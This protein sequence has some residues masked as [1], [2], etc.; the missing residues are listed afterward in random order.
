MENLF[1][2]PS[3]PAMIIVAAPSAKAGAEHKAKLDRQV[4]SHVRV[5]HP[6]AKAVE[7]ARAS[8]ALIAFVHERAELAPMALESA[9]WALDTDDQQAF[10]AF[11][12]E[13]GRKTPMLDAVASA[14]A[15]R[16]ALVAPLPE[17]DGARLGLA[18]VLQALQHGQRGL[19][20]REPLARRAPELLAPDSPLA[21]LLAQLRQGGLDDKGLG[22]TGYD[23]PPPEL[24]LQS[25]DERALP[26]ISATRPVSANRR[27]LLALL[28]GFPMGGYAAF[29]ADFLPRLAASGHAL[30]VCCVEM[31]RSDWQLERV[32]A[33]SDDLHFAP[34]LVGLESMPRYV[35]HLIK[36]RQ[37]ELVLI[38]HAFNGYKMLPWLRRRHPHT[39]FL[40]YVHTDWFE[41]TMYGSYATLA[42][43]HSAFLDAQ[44]ASSQALARELVA[45]GADPDCTRAQTINLDIHEWDPARGARDQARAALGCKEGQPLVLYAGRASSEKRP[46]L[47]V[48]CWKGL[49]ESGVDARFAVVGSGPLLP[50]MIRAVGEAGLKSRVV[51]LGELGPPELRQVYAAADVFHAPSEIEGIARSL[52][53]AMAMECV[54]VVAD[55]GGQRELVDAGVG[56]LLPHGP[57]ELNRYVTALRAATSDVGPRLAKA[58]RARI[59]EMFS[60]GLCVAGFESIFELA[61]ARRRG[62]NSMSLPA[63][64]M[65]SGANSMSDNSISSAGNSISG[66]A[67]S[68]APARAAAA[69]SGELAA[70]ARELAVD[71]LEIARRHFWRAAAARH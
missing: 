50:E 30:T 13:R 7:E 8:G 43:N 62:S 9:W 68:P 49:V 60:A 59:V 71:G 37:I 56:Y 5:V 61:L 55:V 29:N 51:F 28:Q 48:A 1:L 4:W 15:L 66:G 38:S 17:E 58:A 67:D 23:L 25:L 18:S 39:A 69:D 6:L 11:G 24:P 10:V 16:G 70:A 20:I 65:L 46:L 14:V 21:Q 63:N 22:D 44:V 57:D 53:E 32:R 54:P 12:D 35:S 36:S 42:A 27:R 45:R 19:L 52:F 33:A 2:T 26:D 64:S 34:G 41:T 3:L 40:D 31:W 47:A